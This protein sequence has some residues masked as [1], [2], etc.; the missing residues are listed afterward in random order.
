MKE[1]EKKTLRRLTQTKREISR[2][3]FER[4]E[5]GSVSVEYYEKKKE[6]K[7]PGWGGWGGGGWRRSKAKQRGGKGVGLLFLFFAGGRGS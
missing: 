7:K 5:P 6:R 3:V 2:I 4:Q 1:E